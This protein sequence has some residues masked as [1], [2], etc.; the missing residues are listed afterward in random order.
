MIDRICASRNLSRQKR[1]EDARIAAFTD[2]LEVVI[3]KALEATT[4]RRRLS[5][6]KMNT[7]LLRKE[8]FQEQLRQRWA[9]WSK[10]TKNC[11][12]EVMWWEEAG[13]S[14]HQEISS[15]KGL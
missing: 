4:M 6:W 9:Q 14:A 15:V 2:H 7:T 5:Y 8:R 10:Q 11:P 1:S 3:R 12:T 13:K